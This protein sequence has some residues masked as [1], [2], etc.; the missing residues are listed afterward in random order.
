MIASL[1]GHCW[2]HLVP[3]EERS[4]IEKRWG[5]QIRPAPQRG[6]EKHLWG[7]HAW[8]IPSNI[9]VGQKIGIS[10]SQKAGVL[11]YLLQ[12]PRN[13]LPGWQHF[14]PFTFRVSLASSLLAKSA[15]SGEPPIGMRM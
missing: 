9:C 5:P 8:S 6:R 15:N 1:L 12:I 4:F 13:G 10:S 11:R 2:S 7:A 3:N 14:P